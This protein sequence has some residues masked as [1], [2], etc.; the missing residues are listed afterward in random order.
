MRKISKTSIPE[1]VSG[2]LV[3]QLEPSLATNPYAKPSPSTHIENIIQ[4]R[5]VQDID[6]VSVYKFVDTCLEDGYIKN[7][8]NKNQKRFL[9]QYDM[10]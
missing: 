2:F 1:A 10:I 9:P 8:L 5:K 7:L 4:G 6:W 3:E